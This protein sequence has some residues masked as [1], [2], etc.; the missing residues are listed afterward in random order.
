MDGFEDNFSMNP[1]TARAQ[2]QIICLLVEMRSFLKINIHESPRKC[3][4]NRRSFVAQLVDVAP[5][6]KIA[7]ETPAINTWKHTWSPFRLSVEESHKTQHSFCALVAYL[8]KYLEAIAQ[9]G[10]ETARNGLHCS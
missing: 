10:F 5:P 7:S 3:L 6:S 9:K 8:I 1:T 4:I 2:L